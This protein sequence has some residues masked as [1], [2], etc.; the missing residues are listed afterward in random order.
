MA[1]PD[2]VETTSERSAG[3][4]NRPWLRLRASRACDDPTMLYAFADGSTRGSYA[5]VLVR[6]GGAI[7]EEARWRPPTRTRNV[8]AEWDG[9]LL[10]LEL[11]PPGAKLTIVVDLLWIHAQLID[12]RATHDAEIQEKLARAKALISEKRLALTLVHHDGHQ[13]D[14]SDFTRWNARADALCDAKAREQAP[15]ATKPPAAAK[16]KKKAATRKTRGG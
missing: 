13:E 16:S 5:A 15:G 3:M 9:F 11:A 12:V 2:H 10:G 1:L 4:K 8:G 6:P 7:Q 14:A